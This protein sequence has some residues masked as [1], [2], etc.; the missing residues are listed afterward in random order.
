M[1]KILSS[2]VDLTLWVRVVLSLLVLVLLGVV[3]L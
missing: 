2:G 3:V 1:N